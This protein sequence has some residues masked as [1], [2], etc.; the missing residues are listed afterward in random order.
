VPVAGAFLAGVLGSMVLG[1]LTTL[2]ETERRRTEP[3]FL[4]KRRKRDGIAIAQPE[5]ASEMDLT[6]QLDLVGRIPRLFCLKG[7]APIA[8]GGEDRSGV[9][10]SGILGNAID[11]GDGVRRERRH[12]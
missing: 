7:D 1:L 6:E 4:G 11:V 2:A 12:A 10:G 3:L 5:G 9:C 8:T